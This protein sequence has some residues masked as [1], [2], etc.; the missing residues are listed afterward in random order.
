MITHRILIF[1]FVLAIGS[2]HGQVQ[3]DSVSTQTSMPNHP[4]LLL[5]KGE[6]KELLQNIKHDAIWSDIHVNLL[7]AAD[8]I[9]SEP[10]NK[11]VLDGRRLLDI[12]RS[13]LRRLFFLSYAYRMTGNVKYAKRAESEMLK[14]VS[15]SDWNPAHY[16]DVAEM[17]LAM[18][19]GY[20]WNF[21]ML[22]AE[23]KLKIKQAIIEKGLNSSLKTN[24]SW[25]KNSNNWNQVCNTGISLGALA[26]YEENP[27]LSVRLLN[28][29]LKS[30][31]ISMREYAPDGAYP[32][33]LGYWSYGTTF[34]CVFLNAVQKIY[35]TDFSLS[36]L[37]GFMETGMFSQVMV[38]PSLNAFCHSDV[39]LKTGFEPA[40]FWF[41]D[42]TSNP[43]LLFNQKKMIETDVNK[44]Y[45]RDR[46]LPLALIW[47]ASAHSSLSN[48]AAAK[49]LMWITQGRIPVAVMRSS[50]TDPNAI[51]LGYKGGTPS[52][53]HAHMDGGSFFFEANGVK[54][55]MDLGMQS[56]GPLEKAG[57][58]LWNMAQNSS[59]WDV[60]RLNNFSHNT[61]TIN[62]EKQLVNGNATIVNYTAR[63]DFM[64][65]ISDLTSL[66]S[67][68]VEKVMRAV[69]LVNKSYVVVED[70][71]TTGDKP[72]KL[73]W[74]MTTEATEISKISDNT[75]LLKY[76]N[77][78]LF[79]KIVGVSDFQP[80][81]KQAKPPREYDAPNP[82]ISLTGFEISL[83]A[84]STRLVRVFLIPENDM[85]VASIKPI[86]LS[87][88]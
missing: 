1:F 18:A 57:V 83:P 22:S 36:Q 65:V 33:G 77:K 56:Y 68:T 60:Y 29:A 12:S 76:K 80:Y 38:S 73:R 30:L 64:S 40:V 20:D 37:P 9:L 4:R 25:L 61:L 81:F 23:S 87:L 11:R 8:A 44:K 5:L 14:I 55:G 72:I 7:Q 85:D 32:E 2:L 84:N 28:R 54:W 62:N 59:R 69:G 21:D 24:N 74:N 10:L 53:N 63:P 26:V 49:E 43:A 27:E 79:L 86:I 34:N 71:I 88:N 45:L 75:L 39:G 50:W 31:P 51:Y 42:K 67:N 41:Y 35:K 6:E 58:D 52:S 78:K 47:G 3:N 70:K 48:I 19:I 15:F 16:L 17:T 46:F 13:N 66:Y 82:R